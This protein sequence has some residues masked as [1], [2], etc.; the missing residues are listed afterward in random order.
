[1]ANGQVLA[2]GHQGGYGKLVVVRHPNGYKTFYGHLSGF[3]KGVRKG[4][5]VTQGQLIGY[6]GATGLATGP[7]LHFEMRVND[8]PVD[9]RKVVIPRRP[10]R[11]AGAPRLVQGRPGRACGPARL[12][13]ADAL[14]DGIAL[15]SPNRSRNKERPPRD[16]GG[17]LLIVPIPAHAQIVQSLLS[18]FSSFFRTF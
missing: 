7:H 14:R 15:I 9:P 8:R 1:M 3:A 16:E 18:V 17:L 5:S 2:A 10:A 12:G 4:A 6:V 11:A 13:P